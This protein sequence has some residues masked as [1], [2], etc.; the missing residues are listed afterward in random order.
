MSLELGGP[1]PQHNIQRAWK[2]ESVAGKSTWRQWRKEKSTSLLESNENR[3]K[4]KNL[5]GKTPLIFQIKV[6]IVWNNVSHCLVSNV[7][8]FENAKILVGRMTINRAEKR[9]W[10]MQVM[11]LFYLILRRDVLMFRIPDINQG[12]NN[13]FETE[14][15]WIYGKSQPHK[16]FVYWV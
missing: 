11:C 5:W 10:P 3:E 8:F 12:F 6:K 1:V 13:Y 9:E 7:F 4:P 14:K 16:R 15:S 2:Q